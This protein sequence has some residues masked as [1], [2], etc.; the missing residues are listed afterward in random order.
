MI[1]RIYFLCTYV[2]N[3]AEENSRTYYDFS[4]VG[5]LIRFITWVLET[6]SLPQFIKL[7]LYISCK[8]SA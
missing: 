1:F 7:F 3:I 5:V 4:L 6:V 8:K 2:Q